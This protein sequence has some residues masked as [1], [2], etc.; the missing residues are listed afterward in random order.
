MEVRWYVA[1][2]R[3]RCE[4]KLAEF[5]QRE[6]FAVT[7]PLY[8]SVKRYRGKKV[9]FRK[10]LFPGYVFVQVVPESAPKVR[11]NQYVA[12]LLEPGDQAEFAAQLAD[13]LNALDTELE[14]RLEPQIIEGQ[15]V[16]IKHG[17]LRGLEGVVVQRSGALEVHLRLDFIGQAAALRLAADELEPV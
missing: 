16:K 8:R 3:P 1:H 17:A 7:L 4:K 9:E 5:C 13:I 6:G 15:R 14:I 11:Q 10:P 12:N 2:V